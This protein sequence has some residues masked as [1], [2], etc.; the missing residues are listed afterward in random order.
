MSMRLILSLSVCITG[1]QTLLLP[2]QLQAPEQLPS[3]PRTLVISW[4][5]RGAASQPVT[6]LS[7]SLPVH[8]QLAGNCRTTAPSAPQ[9]SRFFLASKQHFRGGLGGVAGLGSPPP[10]IGHSP[11]R[12]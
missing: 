7:A 8:Q 12:N 1:L 9:L 4:G 10:R 11:F 6:G 5:V 3:L 2:P